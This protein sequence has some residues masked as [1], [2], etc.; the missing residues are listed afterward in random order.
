MRK[1]TSSVYYIDNKKLFEALRD[2]KKACRKAKREKKLDPIPSEYI[3]ECILLLSRRIGTRSCFS[4]YSFLEEMISDGVENSIQYGISNFDPNRSNP[5]SYFTQIIT[6]AFI[7]RIQKERK[8]QYIKLKN[9]Q[10]HHL[11]EQLADNSYV[12]TNNKDFDDFIAKF[13]ESVAK[14]KQKRANTQVTVEVFIKST[15]P[16]EKRTGLVPVRTSGGKLI[17]MP[18]KDKSKDKKRRK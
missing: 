18:R 4:G 10:N 15:K 9:M 13:E 12:V 2:H 11:S 7:R 3:G 14:K 8:Q 6:W 17:V 5:F 1:T 16:V